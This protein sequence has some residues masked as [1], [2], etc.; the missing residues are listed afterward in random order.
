MKGEETL[1]KYDEL[2]E[3]KKTQGPS[4]PKLDVR[5]KLEEF[6]VGFRLVTHVN[7]LALILTSD[8][9]SC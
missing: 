3:I 6:A 1:R 9:V 7:F 8:H 4:I 5:T 2:K